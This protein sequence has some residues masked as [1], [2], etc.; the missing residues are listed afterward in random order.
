MKPHQRDV[1]L[2]AR[3]A[4]LENGLRLLVLE[5]H[6]APVVSYQVHYAAGSRN[7]RPGI[8]GISHLFEHMMFKGTP[9]VGPEKLARIIQAHGGQINAFT[10]EDNTT[11]Y[12]NLPAHCL[13]LAMLLEAD[14]QANLLLT[15]ENLASE[16][17]VVRNE[18]LLRTVNTPYGL[19]RELLLSLAFQSHPYSWPVVGWDCD[20]VALT[21]EDCREYF[22]TYYAVNNTTVVVAGDVLYDQVLEQAKDTY[23]PLPAR[24]E[25]RPVVTMDE[26]QLGERRAIHRRKVEAA[27]FFAGF[28]IPSMTHPDIFPLLILSAI[29]SRGESS[30]LFR[31]LVKTGKAG[32]VSTDVGLSFL[33]HDP[34]L[35]QVEAI[36]H[37][38][39]RAEPLEKAV[40]EEFERVCQDG[41]REDEVA[42]A[43]KQL[44][45]EFVLQAETNF[46]RGLQLGLYQVRGHDWRFVNQLIPG[47]RSVTPADVKRVAR[48]YL[49]E[50]NRTVVTAV[51][52]PS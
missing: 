34:M 7:E 45:A 17:E 16:R 6:A 19:A 8:T 28:H 49:R 15:E 46:Y 33:N 43:V 29:L 5:D 51:P 41:P 9:E 37:P 38:G 30:R 31:L 39:D 26:P 13:G 4:L 24:P 48:T 22:Q 44:V 40:W 21:L 11:Y 50:D 3:E 10:T 32:S 18:R 47:Y 14:R 2:E 42:R 25:P 52:E 20:L 27:A 12:E 35:F 1:V 36:A 23:G